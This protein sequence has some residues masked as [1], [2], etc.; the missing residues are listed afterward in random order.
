MFESLKHRFEAVRYGS[1]EVRRRW[2]FGAVIGLFIFV[3]LI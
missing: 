3:I 1:I 2:F